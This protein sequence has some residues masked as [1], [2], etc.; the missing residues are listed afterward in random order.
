MQNNAMLALAI[1]PHE[2][3]APAAEYTYGCGNQLSQ[4]FMG[5]ISL[6]VTFVLLPLFS[7]AATFP[8]AG[9]DQHRGIHILPFAPVPLVVT[10]AD[11]NNTDP[12]KLSLL[13]A[14]RLV[15]P[16]VTIQFNIPGPNPQVIATPVDGYPIITADNVTIDGYTQP[17]SSPN[18]NPILAANNAKIQVIIDSSDSS[19]NG[20]RTLLGPLNNPGYGD[21]ESAIFAIQ[22]GKKFKARGLS[23]RSRTT[24]GSP[25]DPDIYCFAFIDAA[26]DAQISGCWFG[27]DPDGITLNPCRSSVAS[28]KGNNGAAATGMIIGTDGDG[29]DDR[30]EFNVHEGMQLAINLE[31]PDVRVA[32]N[33]INVLPDGVTILDP[34]TVGEAIENGAGA[35]MVI[36]TNGDGVSDDN[37]RNVIGSVNY[38]VVAEF[39]RPGATN[40]IF[41]GNYV[42]MNINK[43]ATFQ[44]AVSLVN[45]RKQSSIRIGSNGDGVSDVIEA[46]IIKSLTGPTFIRWNGSNADN[47]GID[48]AKVVFRQ[49]YLQGNAFGTIPFD[50]GNPVSYS[51]YYQNYIADAATRTDFAPTL[52]TNGTKIITGT[53]PLATPDYP[54]QGIDFYA[55]DP[56]AFAAGSIH[57]MQYIGSVTDNGPGDADPAVGQFS[58][59]VSALNLNFIAKVTAAVTYSQS[60]KTDATNAVTS[61]FAAP[62][63]VTP[64]VQAE[65]RLSVP[66]QTDTTMT[67]SWTGGPGR[68]LLQKKTDLGSATWQDYESTTA[69]TLTITKTG[70]LGFFRL[71]GGYT[72]PD[73]IPT[74]P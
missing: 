26:T 34:S 21:T 31:T 65:I 6:L 22:D 49:N 15:S 52:Q 4:G 2:K 58:V 55:V 24:F 53:F 48:A 44:N 66:S 3:V 33:F 71:Q 60:T 45:I 37:E 11:N 47:D 14:L 32:G 20:G 17:G 1:P 36:G 8:G 70:Q 64:A 12:Q 16:G 62:V 73:V 59:Q 69:Q 19:A 38:D 41:A 56:D 43:T 13:Q 74:N 39:W 61:P 23:F 5:K 35:N 10:T 50:D 51:A 57:P 68:F 7:N 42:G 30:G 46:N 40:M 18:T 27:V 25:D 54:V 72:G 67:I 9:T 63:D 28:F 29:V